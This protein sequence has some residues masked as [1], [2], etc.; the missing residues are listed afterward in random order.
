MAPNN[1][2][3]NKFHTVA[4]MP[5]GG[6]FTAQGLHLSNGLQE[7]RENDAFNK[8]K[9]QLQYLREHFCK[10]IFALDPV[11]IPVSQPIFF[12]SEQNRVFIFTLQ[13]S[14]KS[15]YDVSFSLHTDFTRKNLFTFKVFFF[16]IRYIKSNQI[17]LSSIRTLGRRLSSPGKKERRLP[18]QLQQTSN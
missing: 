10:I 13:L 11:I 12:S 17:I 16:H 15:L 4:S 6:K 5:D 2:S 3:R 9:S 8:T 1:G 14:T 7:G 18:N